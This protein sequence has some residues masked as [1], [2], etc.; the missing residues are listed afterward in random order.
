MRCKRKSCPEPAVF[1]PR[2]GKHHRDYRDLQAAIVACTGCRSPLSD[3]D[4][5]AG[6]TRCPEHR[7]K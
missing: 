1:G 2:C 5:D 6:K 3:D 7:K 4:L